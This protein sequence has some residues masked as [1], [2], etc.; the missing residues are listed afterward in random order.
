MAWGRWFAAALAVAT[1]LGAACT[2]GGSD[3]DGGAAGDGPEPDD[4]SDVSIMT[5]DGLVPG[6]EWT[7]RQDDYLTWATEAN[8]L[9]PGSL[10]SVLAHVERAR[11]DA[12]FEWDTDAITPE[13]LEPIVDKLTAYDDTGDFDINNMLFLW[14]W[15]DDLPDDYV[16][17][18]EE[19]ILGF[20]YWWTEPTPEGVIDDQFYW[21]ENHQ[22]IF[23]A[24][25]YVA[26]QT[27]PDE[28]FTNSGMTGE[29]HMA[30]AE[31][32]IRRWIDLRARFGFS[33][34]L[35]N[36]YFGEDLK[37]LLLLADR[38]DDPEIATLAAMALDMG[39]VEVASHTQDG[40]FGATHGRSYMKDKMTAR[41]EDT[42]SLMKMVVDD[43]ALDY[44]AVDDGI[45]LATA[46]RYRP[47]EVVRQIARSNDT[48]VVR[49]RQSLPLDPTLPYTPDPE[50][51]YGLDYDDPDNL[52]VWWGI[53]SQ[54]AWQVLPLTLETID[55]YSLWETDLFQRAAS[56]RPAAESGEIT[57]LQQLAQG[58][59]YQLNAPL[60]SEVNT[61]TW[62]SPDVMLSSAQCW[63]PGQ[64]SEQNHVWQATLDPD[65][66]VFTTH[67]S[68]PV[69]E[70]TDW[71]T[72]STYWTG[73]AASPCTLQ[74][75]NV[76]ISIYAPQYESNPAGMSDLAYEPYTHAYFP[77][78]HFDEVVERDGW[79]IG[80][81]GD[82]YVALWS[83]RPTTWR[84]YDPATEPTRGMTEPFDL[85][86]EGGADNVWLSEVGNATTSTFD[87]FV[88]AVTTAELEVVPRGGTARDGFDVRYA[89]PSQGLLEASW[90]RTI[91]REPSLVVGGTPAD[92][93]DY[94]RWDSP[95]SQVEFDTTAYEVEAGGWVLALDFSTSTRRSSEP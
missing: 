26:G 3:D 92:I 19:R 55:R 46:R 93:G 67:P 83:Y 9:D 90:G 76:S 43:T 42:F 25:E 61:Y 44:Q 39:F 32:L 73:N 75:Q 27:F 38:A 28:V 81:K 37:G 63:R 88:E 66:Q 70:G 14:A 5:G 18:L 82:G 1:L 58:L 22:I 6:D 31:P 54:F 12:D 79:V 48:A 72:N 84:T 2:S 7:A 78:E 50:A 4:A 17:V 36:V 34:W 35:S 85:L 45:L 80:R 40:A 60:L 23:L 69:P 16:D 64:R 68:T 59:A 57:D 91:E 65:A 47:P 77:T 41:D 20:K 95:W 52:M 71:F 29:E 56:L 8:A 89:S 53:G 11:R 87:E 13:V 21:T 10:H 94:P 62:R 30:H 49:Q 74:H 51:P 15:R 86:A 24:N 33:E